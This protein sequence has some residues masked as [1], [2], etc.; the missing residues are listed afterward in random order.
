MVCMVVLR[1][2][3]TDRKVPTGIMTDLARFYETATLHPR[4]SDDNH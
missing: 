4:Q 2:P 1:C 3:E